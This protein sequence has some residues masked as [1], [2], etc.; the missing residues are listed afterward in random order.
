[1]DFWSV[2]ARLDDLKTAEVAALR[3]GD[4]EAAKKGKETHTVC[5]E[6]DGDLEISAL[7]VINTTYDYLECIQSHLR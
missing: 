2:K 5:N 3:R 1:M 4:A 7:L 6:G